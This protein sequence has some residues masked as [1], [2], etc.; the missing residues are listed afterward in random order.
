MIAQLT[1]LDRLRVPT[2]DDGSQMRYG[3]LVIDRSRCRECGIC[4]RICPGACLVTDTVTKMSLL[5]G[6]AHKGKSGVPRLD[7]MKSGE[8]G[9][10]ACFDCGTAC[11]HGAISLAGHFNPG[12]RFKRIAQ[13]DVLAYPQRY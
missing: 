1:L 6:T 8:A 7:L 2:Y 3:A 11:P 5:N 9:C 12:Y 13:E 10:I 4:V